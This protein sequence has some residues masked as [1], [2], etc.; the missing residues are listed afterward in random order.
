MAADLAGQRFGRWA[1][2]SRVQDGPPGPIH[3]WCICDCGTRKMVAQSSLRRGRSKSCGCLSADLH[4]THGQTKRPE[5]Q[6][7]DQMKQRCL[8]PRHH[9]YSSYGGRG[10]RVHEDWICSFAAFLEAVGP[11]PSPKHSLDR[12]DN[13]GHYE[14]GNVRW[15]TQSQQLRN[16]RRNRLVTANGKTQTLADWADETGLPYNTIYSRFR[17]GWSDDRIV[18]E[19]WKPRSQGDHTINIIPEFFVEERGL[20]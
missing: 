9:S 18:N 19:P 15:I 1:V 11:R 12:I 8:N 5:F 4:R 20:A 2:D 13:S 17:L 14:P 3:W 10:I 16:T 7:W 6:I